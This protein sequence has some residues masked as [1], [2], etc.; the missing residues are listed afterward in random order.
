MWELFHLGKER[1]ANSCKAA[2]FWGFNLAV[3]SECCAFCRAVSAVKERELSTQSPP[4]VCPGT[5]SVQ[6]YGM[7]H[8]STAWKCR[9]FQFRGL[10]SQDRLYLLPK[11]SIFWGYVIQC[12]NRIR[13][14]WSQRG[15]EAPAEALSLQT[16]HV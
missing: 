4:G 13:T 12:I 14:V 2:G 11:G 9:V 1:S 5:H 16:K 6:G 7:L 10:C 8:V 3:P 15:N